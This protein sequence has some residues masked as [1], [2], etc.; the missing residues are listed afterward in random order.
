MP[1]FILNFRQQDQLAPQ[2]RSTG[3]PVAFRLHAD[4]FRVGVLRDLSNERLTVGLGHPVPG[5]DALLVV[6]P[7]LE[8]LGQLAFVLRNRDG[9]IALGDIKALRV[10][11]GTPV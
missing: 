11:N 6:D 9:F 1:T 5:F 7:G 4:D 10:H 2:G 8:L 3:D